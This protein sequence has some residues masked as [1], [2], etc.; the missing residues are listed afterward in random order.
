LKKLRVGNTFGGAAGGL[1]RRFRVSLA[2]KRW[3]NA[4]AAKV[5]SV[6]QQLIGVFQSRGSVGKA[7][8]LAHTTRP[9]TKP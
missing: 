7:V 2:N 6:R 1:I 9:A 5:A 8:R 4:G 3:W